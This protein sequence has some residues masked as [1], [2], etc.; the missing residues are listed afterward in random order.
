MENCDQFGSLRAQPLHVA[1]PFLK[2]AGGKSQLLGK[3][4]SLYPDELK[5]KKVETY[6]EAFVGSGAVFFEIIRNY[7]AKQIVIIDSNKDLIICYKIIKKNVPELILTLSNLQNEYWKQSDDTRVDY[8]N[9]KRKK[10]NKLRSELDYTKMNKD[11]IDCAALMI[12]LNKTCFNGLYRVNSSGGFNVPIGSQKKPTICDEK[13]LN[14]VSKVL[15]N[16]EIIEGDYTLCENYASENTF[17]YFDP[18]YRP[19]NKSSSFNSYSSTGF[20]D[21]EQERL[22]EFFEKMNK[23]KTKLMLS[24]SDPKNTDSTDN[25]FDELYSKHEIVR[26]PAVR[27]INS[28]GDERGKITEI[29]VRN[30]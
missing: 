20:N 6:V 16:I 9:N 30:Y 19:L 5:N 17:I 11:W 29:V 2:W 26:V 28:K 14:A 10:F 3:F 27:A 18:P 21:N 13:N 22:A 12:F 4:E 7:N 24:N 1:K 8:Y 23:T 25:F 15:Q